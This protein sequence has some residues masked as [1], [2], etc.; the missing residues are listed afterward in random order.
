MTNNKTTQRTYPIRTEIISD[1]V[2]TH[3]QKIAAISKNE[4]FVIESI[5]GDEDV[6][7]MIGEVQTIKK[8]Y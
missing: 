4:K 6:T 1:L 3:A 8:E 2:T 7:T 5:E